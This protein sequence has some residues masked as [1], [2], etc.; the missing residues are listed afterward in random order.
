M[1]TSV[2]DP[3]RYVTFTATHN[4]ASAF[5]GGSGGFGGFSVPG[6]GQVRV[7][8]YAPSTYTSYV[9]PGY[10]FTSHGVEFTL[11]KCYTIPPMTQV[12]DYA[13]VAL[14]DGP[15]IVVRLFKGLEIM[16]KYWNTQIAD[17]G[18]EE[19]GNKKGHHG[20]KEAHPRKNEN[21]PGK[22]R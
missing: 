10:Y 22:N 11:E 18:K 21:R 20:K 8:S 12:L 17:P 5:S 9:G 7:K 15:P 2:L 1:P 19:D 4:Y 3:E 13:T 14:P 16:R 6:S